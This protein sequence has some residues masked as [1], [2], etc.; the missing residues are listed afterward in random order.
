MQL[1]INN[2]FQVKALFLFLLQL[3]FKNYYWNLVFVTTMQ[4]KIN[5]SFQVK[6]LF[7]FLLQF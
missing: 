6:A 7:L 2:S 5:N 1:K 4:L 3:E